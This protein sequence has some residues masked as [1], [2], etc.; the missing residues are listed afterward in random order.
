MVEPNFRR[1]ARGFGQPAYMAIGLGVLGFQRAQVCRHSL[2]RH[3]GELASTGQTTTKAFGDDLEQRLGP[4]VHSVAG[5]AQDIAEH[6]PTEARDLLGAVGNLTGD[7]PNEARAALGEA[8]SL[9]RF[10]LSVLRPP[11]AAQAG[12]GAGR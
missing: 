1:I 8:V 3:F 10:A 7:L 6:L 9:A 4:L 5:R 2:Q 12:P 11:A